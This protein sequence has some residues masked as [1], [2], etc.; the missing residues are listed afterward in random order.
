MSARALLEEY[1]RVVWTEGD[2]DAIGRFFAPD[3][4]AEGI[5]P[6]DPATPEDLR[7]MAET[8]RGLIRRPRFRILR[9]IE[10]GEWAS[11]LCVVEGPAAATGRPLAIQGQ[12]IFR[13]DGR[14]IVEAHNTFDMLSA[15]IQLGALSSDA[16]PALLGGRKVA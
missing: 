16:V 3:A 1:W 8:V 6:P 4:R 11:A 5:L 9:F 13:T 2:L 15:C 10:D 14:R 12:V 7:V